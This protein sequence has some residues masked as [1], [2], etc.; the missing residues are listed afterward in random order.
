MSKLNIPK[1][2]LNLEKRIKAGIKQGLQRSAIELAGGIAGG[3]NAG[4]IQKEMFK[5]PKTGKTYTIRRRN[6]HFINHIASNASGLESSA[7]LTGRLEK[8]VKGKT[9]GFDRLEIS[10]NTPYAAIQE[11]GGRNG[12]GTYVAPRNNLIRPI[13][14]SRGNIINNIKQGIDGLKK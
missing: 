13:K 5:Q 2:I 12:Q 8:S 4:L 11:K 9:L 7:I 6:K 3:T 10:A 14:Q 1:S